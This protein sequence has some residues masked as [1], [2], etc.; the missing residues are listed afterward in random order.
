MATRRCKGNT[1]AGKRCKARPLR[2]RNHCSAH[3][4]DTPRSN[5]FGSP[6]QAATAGA[7]GGRPKKPRATEILRDRVE[8]DVDRWVQPF[9]EALAAEAPVVVGTGKHATLEMVTDHGTRMRA[10]IAVLDRVY[11]RP[12]QATE[13]SGPDGNPIEITWDL[14]ALSDEELAALQVLAEKAK[15]DEPA[16]R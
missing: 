15:P 12:K 11:G 10:A 6:E 13:I 8:N 4:P 5:R 7:A 16:E 3:D 1:K 14:G 2:G 9:E